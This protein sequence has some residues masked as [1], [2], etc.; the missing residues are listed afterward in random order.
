MFQFRISTIYS[1]YISVLCENVNT[2]YS[3][4]VINSQFVAP[5]NF[6]SRLKE[7][8]RLVGQKRDGE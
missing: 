2:I 5:S 3:R 7:D 8:K 4:N 1:T 6:G